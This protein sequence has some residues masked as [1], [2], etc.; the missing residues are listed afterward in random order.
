MNEQIFTIRKIK[1]Y[2]IKIYNK[3]ISAEERF[4]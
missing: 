4:E 1:I 2:D 3:I